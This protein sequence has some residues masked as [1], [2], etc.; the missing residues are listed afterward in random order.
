MQL[1]MGVFGANW[2][3]FFRWQFRSKS[4]KKVVL[5]QMTSQSIQPIKIVGA[6]VENGSSDG[7]PSGNKPSGEL[8]GMLQSRTSGKPVA[9]QVAGQAEGQME[10]PSGKLSGR[11]QADR[12]GM[13]SAGEK[14]SG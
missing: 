8:F 1:T 7:K 4:I 2:V 6:Y 9:D 10:K 11:P 13:S 14:R 5:L 12:L 3:L